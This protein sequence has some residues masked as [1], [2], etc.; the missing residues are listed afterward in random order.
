[1]DDSYQVVLKKNLATYLAAIPVGVYKPAAP[2][3]ATERGIFTTG[4][5]VPTLNEFISLTTLTPFD[6]GRWNRVTPVQ[7]RSRI[8]GTR[9]DADN[10]FELIDGSLHDRE[11]LQ[12]G[13]LTFRIVQR[14]SALFISADQT[15]RVGYFQTYYFHGRKTT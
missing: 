6:D 7:I 14:N 2:Y 8:V 15:K 5:D 11:R 10:L 1:M 4:P 9:N 13:P 3:L 12:L